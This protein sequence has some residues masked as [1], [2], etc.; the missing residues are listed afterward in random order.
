MWRAWVLH[1]TAFDVFTCEKAIFCVC[2]VWDFFVCVVWDF[3][4]VCGVGLFFVCVVWDFF[5][6]V[7]VP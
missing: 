7:C 6:F 2:V 5:V 3:F 4:R 1:S